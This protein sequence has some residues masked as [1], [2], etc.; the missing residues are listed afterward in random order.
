MWCNIDSDWTWLTVH[1]W[2]ICCQSKL[3]V[4]NKTSIV[5]GTLVLEYLALKQ[6]L[7]KVNG[8]PRQGWCQGFICR[9]WLLLGLCKVLILP[10]NDSH[11]W[12]LKK[13]KLVK[14][15][16]R[17]SVAIVASWHDVLGCTTDH[18]EERSKQGRRCE[19]HRLTTLKPGSGRSRE[20]RRLHIVGVWGHAEAG[21]SSGSLRGRSG[22]EGL[23]ERSGCEVIEERSGSEGIEGKVRVWG[24]WGKVMVWGHWGKVRVWGNW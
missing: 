15:V 9:Y 4:S 22:C 17:C 18:G 13:I 8:S 12:Y 24:H 21:Q 3:R 11:H 6:Y 16:L 2:R 14:T 7:K 5:L 19:T 1:A 20:R 23:R 10:W